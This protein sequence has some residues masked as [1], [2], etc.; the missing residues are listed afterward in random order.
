M[1]VPVPPY[2]TS[3]YIRNA[4]I[5]W[6]A[7]I[8]TGDM[9][10]QTWAADGKIYAGAGD[11]QPPGLYP[12]PLNVW[13][14]DGNPQK[15]VVELVNHSPVSPERYSKGPGVH[16]T[17][18]LKPAGL[19]HLDGILYM[20][21]QTM[22]YGD[23]PLFNRQHNINGW[24]V[25]SRDYGKTWDCDA[26]PQDFFSGR[27][28]S[29]HFL[30]AGKGDECVYDGYVWAYFPCALDSD[31]S[32]WCNGDRMML[33]RV[34]PEFILKRLAWEVFDGLD[35]DGK[36]KFSGEPT[37]PVFSYPYF[38]GEN[39]VSYN[40]Y[41]KR[42]ILCNY[43]FYN[44]ETGEPRPY[45][46]KPYCDYLTQLSMYE[47]EYPW[48]PWRL[49]LRDD[50]WLIGGYQPSVPVKWMTAD[51]CSMTLLASGNGPNYCFVTQG[52]EYDIVS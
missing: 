31:D 30:Q 22:N 28:A 23:R 34:R 2:P 17:A 40:P 18:G 6:T 50:D 45:H 21:V 15:P 13:S 19:I 48:G 14:A 36:P 10:P 12:S 33:A 37:R 47:A 9:W 3:D 44:P 42:F 16:R 29:C 38:C 5:T 25:T 20:S 46:N 52:L 35:K 11:N 24:I 43:A 27:F 39:H 32:W 51:G 1:P 41:I 4:R 26:T 8:A 7:R 49:F